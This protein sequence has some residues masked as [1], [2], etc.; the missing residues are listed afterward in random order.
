[1][2]TDRGA[3]RRAHS[4]AAPAACCAPADPSRCRADP[5]DLVPASSLRARGVRATF[6]GRIGRPPER[7]RA[8]VRA[9]R[10]WDRSGSGSRRRCDELLQ[11]RVLG[12]PTLIGARTSHN[13]SCARESV[14]YFAGRPGATTLRIASRYT[15]RSAAWVRSPKIAATGLCAAAPSITPARA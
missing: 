6:D 7:A 13:S 10:A 9:A 14:G 1:M 2:P 12:E 4:C 11:P 15:E 8:S 3:A 5:L